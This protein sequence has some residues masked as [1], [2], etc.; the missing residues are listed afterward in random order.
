[1]VG[2]FQAQGFRINYVQ[3]A[4]YSPL[5]GV[6]TAAPEAAAS[7]ADAGEPPRSGILNPK[8][9]LGVV[10]SSAPGLASCIVFFSFIQIC[11]GLGFDRA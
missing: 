6:P 2:L 1:M 11:Q 7:T 8:K 9:G 10:T 3:L 5:P 4:K